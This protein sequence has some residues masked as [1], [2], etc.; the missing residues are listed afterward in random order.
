LAC[1]TSRKRRRQPL[2]ILKPAKTQHARTGA[3][4][5]SPKPLAAA[6]NPVVEHENVRGPDYYH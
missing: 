4:N 1:A 5:G 6:D 2:S 3:H